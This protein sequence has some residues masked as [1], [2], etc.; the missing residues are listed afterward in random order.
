MSEA[1]QAAAGGQSKVVIALVAVVVVL[2]GVIVGLVVF[3]KPAT[4]APTTSAD[5]GATGGA[6]SGSTSGMPGSTTQNVPFDP[7]TAT[8]V[9]A[10]KTPEDHVKAYFD[11]VVKGDFATAYDLLPADKKAAQ[12]EAAF[13]EQLK[14]YGITSYKID[15]VS[16]KDGE[17]QVLATASMAGGSFQYLW[18]FVKEGDTWLLKSRTLPGMN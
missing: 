11:A 3:K 2:V 6:T 8:K 5:G 4:P 9:A 12:D 1:P 18:T 15:D 13:A 10:G 14:G 17:T 16:E 7:K